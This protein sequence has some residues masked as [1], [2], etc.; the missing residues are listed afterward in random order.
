MR[1][2]QNQSLSI[3]RR[4]T[5]KLERTKPVAVSATQTL[6]S[7]WST[8]SSLSFMPCISLGN[9][10]T[11]LEPG[12]VGAA[13]PPIM[14]VLPIIPPV[15]DAMEGSKYPRIRWLN[16]FPTSSS[17]ISVCWAPSFSYRYWYPCSV[18]KRVDTEQHYSLINYCHS[19]INNDTS[20]VITWQMRKQIL[21]SWW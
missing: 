10:S 2:L 8:L 12:L 21:A 17:I 3:I 6:S 14:F 20:H 11:P 13:P 1:L 16:Q 19:P 15:A 4:P 9:D 18:E 7:L 5:T